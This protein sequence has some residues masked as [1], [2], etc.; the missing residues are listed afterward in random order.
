M[1]VFH[2][3]LF[4][5]SSDVRDYLFSNGVDKDVVHENDM[6]FFKTC[7]YILV[8]MFGYRCNITEDQFFKYGFAEM[9]MLLS[10]DMICLVKRKAKHLKVHRSMSAK[11]VVTRSSLQH[12]SRYSQIVGRPQDNTFYQCDT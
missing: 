6:K 8:N 4:A 2:Y 7:I 11:R 5:A 3:A 1:K 10:C 12:Q 9:K